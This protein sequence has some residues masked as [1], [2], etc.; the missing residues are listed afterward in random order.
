[1]LQHGVSTNGAYYQ[2]HSTEEQKNA[3]LSLLNGNSAQSYASLI[4][5]DFNI[6]L[7]E[8]GNS[9]VH[10]AAKVGNV[11]LLKTLVQRGTFSI[12]IHNR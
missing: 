4:G 5:M 11:D 9:G 2:S 12:L 8:S 3:V 6:A 10:Y 1:M 7:D